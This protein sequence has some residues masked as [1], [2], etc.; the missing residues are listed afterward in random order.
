MVTPRLGSYSLAQ[1]MFDFTFI[2]NVVSVTDSTV[3]FTAASMLHETSY[4]HSG[5]SDW[6]NMDNPPDTDI[7][8]QR[9]MKHPDS[10]S[11]TFNVLWYLQRA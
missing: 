7:R 11:I 1:D 2:M 3:T 10:I 4:I 9:F 6:G 5:M 8:V